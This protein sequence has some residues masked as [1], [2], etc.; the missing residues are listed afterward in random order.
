MR[1]WLAPS[2]RDRFPDDYEKL[3]KEPG[4]LILRLIKLSEH[5]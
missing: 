3:N 1:A 2:M 5:G 4:F